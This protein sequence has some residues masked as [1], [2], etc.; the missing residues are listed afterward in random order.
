ML[1]ASFRYD[2][3]IAKTNAEF[4]VEILLE[5]VMSHSKGKVAELGNEKTVKEKMQ[6]KTEKG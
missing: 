2:R 6:A 4:E 5:K 1:P 3:T